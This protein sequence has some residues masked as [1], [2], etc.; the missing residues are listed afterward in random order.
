MGGR[1]I[2]RDGLEATNSPSHLFAV[3]LFV[4]RSL[5]LR[6]SSDRADGLERLEWGV[7]GQARLC[8]LYVV[9][10]YTCRTGDDGFHGEPFR[11]ATRIASLDI[12]FPTAC[13]RRRVDRHA[14]IH[15]GRTGCVDHPS[16]VRSADAAQS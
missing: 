11:S 3:L 14:W 10:Q 6:W 1:R 13:G 15:H 12:W 7:R 16:A 9:A 2:E 8:L 5:Q 4:S